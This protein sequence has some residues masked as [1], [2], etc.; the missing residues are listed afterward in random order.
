P[1][2]AQTDYQHS[3]QILWEKWGNS[4]GWAGWQG[5]QGVPVWPCNDSRFKRIISGAYET[6]RP[7]A[8]I[9]PPYPKAGFNWP[10]EIGD[11]KDCRIETDGKSPGLLLC[12]NPWSLNYD[13]LADPGWYMDGIMRCPDGHEY[14]RA[15]YVD[16]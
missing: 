1:D 7:Q 9:N 4:Y 2:V 14:H 10:V 5:P 13:V 11:W 15:W 16:Y 8:I 6:H 3:I 12:G